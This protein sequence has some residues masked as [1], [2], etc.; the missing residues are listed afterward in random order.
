MC[1]VGGGRCF[2]FFLHVLFS[3]SDFGKV[4]T[5]VTKKLLCSICGKIFPYRANLE[6]H[7]YIHTGNK[8][9]SCEICSKAFNQRGH[10]KRHQ[11][12]H[13]NM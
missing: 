13:L 11:I 1:G 9:Y 5:R 4:K 3:F 12:R 7:M 6:T 2:S 8:P 10:L